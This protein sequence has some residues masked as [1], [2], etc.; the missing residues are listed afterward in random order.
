[1]ADPYAAI[2]AMAA[3]TQSNAE[4]FHH[5]LAAK[6]KMVDYFHAKLAAEIA[7]ITEVYGDLIKHYEQDIA[8]MEAHVK[9]LNLKPPPPAEG[10]KTEPVNAGD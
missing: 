5:T 2:D 8:N 6:R 4:Y 1:M 9:H 3:F 10:E 7:H